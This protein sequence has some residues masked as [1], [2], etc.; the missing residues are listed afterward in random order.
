MARRRQGRRVPEP[1]GVPGA[2]TVIRELDSPWSSSSRDL[3]SLRNPR[4]LWYRRS[5]SLARARRRILENSGGTSGR[6]SWTGV[7]S[8]RRMAVSTERGEEPVKGPGAGRHLVEQDPQGEHVGARVHL[9][10]LGLLGRH[11]AEGPHDAA[12]LLGDDSLGGFFRSQG[13]RRHLGQAEVEHLEAPLGIHHHVLGLE[14]PVGD[15][16]LVGAG[17]GVAQR[18]GQLQEI[19]EGHSGRGDDGIQGAPLD[20]FHG[21]EM[22]LLEVFHREDGD[23]VRVIE[24]GNRLGF[25]LEAPGALGVGGQRG[26]K[27]L[28]RH[29]TIQLGIASPVHLPHSSRADLAQDRVMGERLGQGH[30]TLAGSPGSP[31]MRAVYCTPAVRRG[32][33]QVVS[34]EHERR[35]S[36]VLDRRGDPV[37]ARR[38]AEAP[39]LGACR[40]P[41]RQ[42]P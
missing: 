32:R 22:G 10:P 42:E 4:A 21:Q 19:R 6:S 31:S 18:D 1:G 12:G 14:I 20:Q 41:T 36:A 29:V 25:A 27:D 38:R 30:E 24:G 11:V 28:E 5:G 23:D 17:Q 35:A 7:G 26:G 9:F 2:G 16:L 37:G 8:S 39:A 33:A 34:S 40:P 13:S 3:R 15:A